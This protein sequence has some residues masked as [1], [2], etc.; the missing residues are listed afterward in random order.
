MSSRPLRSRH[1]RRRL[2]DWLIAIATVFGLLVISGC[3]ESDPPPPPPPPPAPIEG[4]ISGRLIVP[5]NHQIEV[6]PN[7]TP[8]E[9]QAI[10]EHTRISG[11]AAAA[12]PGYPVPGTSAVLT[13][14]YNLSTVL[15]VSVTLTIG[16][17]NLFTFDPTSDTIIEISNDLDLVVL[18]D[19]G[20]LVAFSEGLTRTES[21]DIST[22]GDYIVGIRAAVG[23]SPYVVAVSPLQLFSGAGPARAAAAK[24]APQQFVPGEVLVKSTRPAAASVASRIAFA[25]FHGAAFQRTLTPGID[26]LTSATG[27][28]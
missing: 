25:K 19:Q 13:D 18:D 28:P 11:A 8:N 15:P 9:A 6:E 7:G 24:V 4:K 3:S 23:S 2:P 12:E 17:N 26:L 1:L 22:P 14:L 5:P 10:G 27:T 16:A 20:N 21:I